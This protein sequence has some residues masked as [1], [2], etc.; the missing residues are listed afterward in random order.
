MN[1]QKRIEALGRMILSADTQ[2]EILK[3]HDDLLR[4]EMS[5]IK[6]QLEGK[7]DKLVRELRMSQRAVVAA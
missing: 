4:R 7:R 5:N 3:C 1:K 6:R 2:M